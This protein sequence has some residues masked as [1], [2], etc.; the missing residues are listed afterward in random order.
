VRPCR[1]TPDRSYTPLSENGVTRLFLPVLPVLLALTVTCA[2]AQ[3]PVLTVQQSGTTAL[4]QAVSVS[5]REPGVV[6]ISGHRGSVTRTIDGG[7]TWSTMVVPGQDSMQFRDVHGID[8][9]RAWLM[10]AGNGAASR[11]L[12]TTDG[13]GTWTPRFVNADSAAFYDCMA[14][15]DDRH[16]FAISDS[17]NGRMPLLRTDDG[18][19]WALSAIDAL[20]GEGG[21]AA[22]GTC[23][24]TNAAGDAWIGTGSAATPRVLHSTDR[25]RR[26]SA[27][28]VPIVSGEGAG[29]TGLAF[30]DRR[31]GIAVGGT[32]SGKAA[33]ARVARTSDGGATWVVAGEPPTAGPLYGVAAGVAAGRPVL[34]A[35]GPGGAVWSGDDGATWTLLDASPYW[36]VGFGAGAT[37]WLAGPR[38][39][40]ARVDFR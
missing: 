27:A 19:N 38:G 34:I 17:K 35:V 21:F 33:G 4:L 40:I 22:S 5:S 14:F 3:A 39:R 20:P 26:W 30:R 25:G 18:E 12:Q 28:V 8:A 36:S 1:P 37:A 31:H 13:G 10:A 6:W 16:A 23:A 15:W 9:Q 7:A 24:L 32:I 29:I 11:I 2:P